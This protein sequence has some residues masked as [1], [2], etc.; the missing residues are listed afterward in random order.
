MLRKQ[1]ALEPLGER[2][3]IDSTGVVAWAALIQAVRIEK[4]DERTIR[5]TN[6][7]Q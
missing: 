3:A 2:A 5:S 7:E 1:S 6:A 4:E